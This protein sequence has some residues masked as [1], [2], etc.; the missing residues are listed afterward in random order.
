LD[1]AADL[2][3]ATVT[4]TGFEVISVADANAG[5]SAA[6]GVTLDGSQIDGLTLTASVDAS[7]EAVAANADT[8]VVNVTVDEATTGLGNITLGTGVTAAITGNDNT[9]ETIVGTKGDDT[10][11]AG[12]VAGALEANT[13]TGGDGDDTFV[14]ASG[15]SDATTTG[16]YSTITDFQSGPA[17]GDNDTISLD[18]SA[19][20]AGADDTA[21]TILS[22]GADQAAGSVNVGG[23]AAAAD[24]LAAADVTA[25]VV[26][27]IF[28]LSG[29]AADKAAFNT[30]AE[31][32]DAAELMLASYEAALGTDAGDLAEYVIAFEFSGDT[33]VMSALDGPGSGLTA[34]IAVD[35]IICL[36]DV[37]GITAVAVDT[38]AANTIEIT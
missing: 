21:V 3:A 13:L 30:V 36:A 29:T 7:S 24:G 20:G 17:T 34:D 19:E 4:L 12:V 9:A 35:D 32:I 28:T 5:S 27:G 31:W 1:D 25:V 38:A 14:F 18:S 23:A 37:T 11:D 33:Y 6:M 26:D 8:L 22:V 16:A 2:A 15:D 10:I